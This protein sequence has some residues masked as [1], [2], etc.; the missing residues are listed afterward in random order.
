MI[1]LVSALQESLQQSKGNWQPRRK[2]SLRPGKQASRP[3]E[4][5]QLSEIGG[6]WLFTLPLPTFPS[7]RQPCRQDANIEPSPSLAFSKESKIPPAGTSK[8]FASLFTRAHTTGASWPRADRFHPSASR[9]LRLARAV[10]PQFHLPTSATQ[11]F[12]FLSVCSRPISRCRPRAGIS[13][14]VRRR[15]L[16]AKSAPLLTSSFS[17]LPT[18]AETLKP[19]SHV[20]GLHRHEDPQAPRETQHSRPIP[21]ARRTS[22]PAR[23]AS[24]YPPACE[25]DFPLP[26]RGSRTWRFALHARFQPTRIIRPARCSR[27]ARPAPLRRFCSQSSASNTSPR[28][29]RELRPVIPLRSYSASIPLRFSGGVCTRPASSTFR[30]SD[31]TSISVRVHPMT[32]MVLLHSGAWRDAYV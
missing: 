18:N 15:L 16:K 25:P 26:Q 3:N 5:R 22:S 19:L 8:I 30:I 7:P 6:F 23:P 1:D 10:C 4:R 28:E 21:I 12:L 31:P 14:R 32:P 17:T 2:R 9:A 20:T 24:G 27:P 13:S 11:R 29:P